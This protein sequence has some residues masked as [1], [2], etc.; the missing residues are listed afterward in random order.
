M[1]RV[2]RVL[3]VI[4]A[5]I[6]ASCAAPQAP[7]PSQGDLVIRNV[8]VVSPERSA[9]YGPVDVLITAGKIVQ[10]GDGLS[11]RAVETIEG[12]GAYL[13]PGLIDSH[14]HLSGVPGMSYEQVEAYP[15]IAQATM[16]QIPRSYLYHGFTSVIDLNADPARIAD[17]N[18]LD[19]RPSAYFCGSA[20]VMDGYPMG[21]IPRAV[22]YQVTPYFLLGDRVAPNGVDPALHAPQAIARRIKNDGAICIKAYHESGFGGGGTQP[23]PA[24]ELI[25]DLTVAAHQQGL[26][27]ILHANSETAQR[28]GL[29]VGVDGF[30]HGMWT[31]NAAGGD[32]LTPEITAVLDAILE[33][34]I[35]VQPTIQVLHGERDLHDPDYLSDARLADVLPQSLIAWYAS[36]AGQAPSTAMADIPYVA[37]L[38]EA[39]GWQALNAV[40]IERVRRGTGYLAARGGRLIFGSDT[41]SDLTYANPP[42]LNGRLEMSQ[43]MKSGVTP[44]QFFHAATLENARFFNLDDRIGSIEVGKDADLLLLQ[45]NPFDGIGAFDGITHVIVR[46]KVIERAKLSARTTP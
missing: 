2:P 44:A 17:W 24:P 20:P 25:R 11:A 22:R 37:Q 10:I 41:P 13:A 21:F 28:F 38:I 19:V 26:P 32:S 1:K 3:L 5:V 6:A 42:G 40:P 15:E 16:A 8:M 7:E 12:G 43:W 39:K 23:V 14:T 27:V 18:A 46:G 9:P 30:A 34:K 29:M 45:D 33:T 31:W 35:A 4:A 36:E